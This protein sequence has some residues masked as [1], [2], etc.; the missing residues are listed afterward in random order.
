MYET[1]IGLVIKMK[2][3]YVIIKN[4]LQR[5]NKW[6]KMEWKNG[7]IVTYAARFLKLNIKKADCE[8]VLP[9]PIHYGKPDSDSFY[10]MSAFD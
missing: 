6:F 8:A 1:K 9:T 3:V 4:R 2:K 7:R 10:H 5:S